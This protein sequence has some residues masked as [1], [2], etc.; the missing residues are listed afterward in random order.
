MQSPDLRVWVT[1]D[2]LPEWPSSLL[3]RPPPWSRF[4]FPVA[5][6]DRGVTAEFLTTEKP[7]AAG[8]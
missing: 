8:K 2:W 3:I 1:S 4:L 6:A 7:F 5:H